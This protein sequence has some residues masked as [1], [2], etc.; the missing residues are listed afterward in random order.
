MED[1]CFII[2]CW[3]LPYINVNQPQ[4]YICPG[5]WDL[6]PLTIPSH[7]ARLSQSTRFELP[8][9]HRKLPLA[10]RMTQKSH[11]WEYTL[12]KP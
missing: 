3:F 11:Y 4:A 9:L 5:L 6:L 12:R 10:I 1:N 2:L 7:P 8:A